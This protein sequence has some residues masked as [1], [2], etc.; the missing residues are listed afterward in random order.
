MQSSV[1]GLTDLSKESP[2]TF[3]RYGI[4]KASDGSF[5]S[6]C[7]LARRMA[8]RGVRFIQLY[9]RGWDHHGDIEKNMPIAAE[10]TDQAGAA[11]VADLKERGLLD[12]TLVLWGGEFGRTPMG[13]G[14]GRDH[15]ILGF[16]VALA[17][18]GIKPGI[19]YGGTDE[20]GYKAVDHPVSMHDL[21]ATMLSLCG[22]DHLQRNLPHPGPRLP[23]DRRLRGGGHGRARVMPPSR[24]VIAIMAAGQDQRLRIGTAAIW[25]SMGTTASPA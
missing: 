8:E 6:N 16:S 5:A 24:P 23:P 4:K 22:V 9:H 7:L 25:A 13:Q 11:L 20:L 1:P 3:E 12:D 18:G 15:H 19:T 10:E 21:H 2:A 17:G 14:S